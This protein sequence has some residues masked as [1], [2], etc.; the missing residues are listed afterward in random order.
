MMKNNTF[1]PQID[2]EGN[3]YK[4]VGV[5]YEDPKNVRLKIQ[6]LGSSAIFLSPVKE[7][8]NNKKILQIKAHQ[9]IFRVCSYP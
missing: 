2:K 9:I 4:L 6:V 7:I 8:Y 3:I 1:L 5:N